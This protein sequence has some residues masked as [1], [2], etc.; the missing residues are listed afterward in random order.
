MVAAV[1]RSRVAHVK[2]R[3]LRG[4]VLQHDLQ[5]REIAAQR[6]QLGVDEHGLAVE[7]VDVGRGHLAVHQQ[8]QA[9]FLHGLQRLV[10]LAHVGDAGIAVGGGAGRVELERNHAGVLGAGNF[11][12]RQVVGEVQRHQRLERTPARHGGLRMRSR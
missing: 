3:F 10:G 6:D 4:D 8:Q 5:P 11:V 7:Q 9:F 2:R 1:K 12:G